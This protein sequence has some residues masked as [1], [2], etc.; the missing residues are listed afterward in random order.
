VSFSVFVGLKRFDKLQDYSSFC[1]ANR[2]SAKK[3]KAQKCLLSLVTLKS[4][5]SD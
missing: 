2:E 1:P 5:G 3:S 4:N